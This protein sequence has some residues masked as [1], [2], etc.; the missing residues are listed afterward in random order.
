MK[1][2]KICI[3]SFSFIFMTFA[4]SPAISVLNKR[5]TD[6]NHVITINMENLKIREG[7]YLRYDDNMDNEFHYPYDKKAPK[8]ITQRIIATRPVIFNDDDVL[9]QGARYVLLAGD[10][11][12]ITENPHDSL[13]KFTSTDSVRNNELNFFNALKNNLENFNYYKITKGIKFGGPSNQVLKEIYIY[14]KSH[15]TKFAL[16]YT[17]VKY[18]DQIAFLKKYAK[19]YSIT[20]KMEKIFE[21]IFYFDYATFKFKIA[22][23]M[24]KKNEKPDSSLAHDIEFFK[25]KISDDNYQY[26]SGYRSSLRNYTIYLNIADNKSKLP[27]YDLIKQNF[28]GPAKDYLLF[29]T[30]RKYLNEQKTDQQLMANFYRDCS[31]NEYTAEIN[32]NANFIGHKKQAVLSDNKGKIITFDAIKQ[33]YKSQKDSV[34]YIDFWASWCVPCIEQMAYSARLHK[35]L[36]NYPIRFLYFSMDNSF[37]SWQATSKQLK[38]NNAD[39]FLVANSF[40]SPLANTFNLTTIPRYIIIDKDGDIISGKGGAPSE[41]HTKELLMKLASEQIASVESNKT[42]SK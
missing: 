32:H 4:N 2:F 22:A 28:S 38:H 5:T 41:K 8:Q 26:I 29:Y 17:S 3:A 13:L 11:V 19:K 36:K 23:T 12:S 15:D 40:H 6:I 7:L 31:N 16:K 10:S 42:D 34:L 20:P 25:Q 18:N 14:Y 1:Y 27:L 30:V 39:N 9:G 33:K 35:E 37:A 21:D 24:A